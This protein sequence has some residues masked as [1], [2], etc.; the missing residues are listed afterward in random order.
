MLEPGDKILD[1]PPTFTM[2]EF[3]AAVNGALVIKG[4][5]LLLFIYW[6][7]QL[8]LRQIINGI[9]CKYGITW[10]DPSCMFIGFLF[11]YAEF[12]T[13]LIL[14][15]SLWFW[16]YFHFTVPRKPD[17]SLDVHRIFEVVEQEKP[18]CI[19]LTSPNNPDGRWILIIIEKLLLL[20]VWRVSYLICCF[21]KCPAFG[22]I[23]FH[24]T[25]ANLFSSFS[26][27]V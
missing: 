18:K 15:P 4:N 3:D 7:C 14:S 19:F 10:S 2:Y 24:T 13:S 11:L 25:V 21:V 17:F 8:F 6:L 16:P 5:L 27:Y 9:C 23:L 22:F 1:C 26:R 20:Q 12:F